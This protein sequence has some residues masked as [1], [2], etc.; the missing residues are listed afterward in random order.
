MGFPRTSRIF[1]K[2]QFAG[3]L[4]EDHLGHME[5]NKIAE[6]AENS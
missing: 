1:G 2:V 5:G 3:D 6:E 4:G